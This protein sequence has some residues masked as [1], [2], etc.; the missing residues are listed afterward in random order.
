MQ[1]IESSIAT[2]LGLTERH[3][4]GIEAHFLKEFEKAGALL[5][6]N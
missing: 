5:N 1:Q 2:Q 3:K 6:G 4:A